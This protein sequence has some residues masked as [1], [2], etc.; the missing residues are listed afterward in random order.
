MM[1]REKVQPHHHV[2]PSLLAYMRRLIFSVVFPLQRQTTASPS[3]PARQW[4][5][6]MKARNK[7]NNAPKADFSRA[8]NKSG[9]IRERVCARLL[10]ETGIVPPFYLIIFGPLGQKNSLR[11]SLVERF[12]LFP[13]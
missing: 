9:R 12:V 2:S 13:C 1:K 4:K 7:R 11:A 3:F 10:R 5:R 8:G 6:H